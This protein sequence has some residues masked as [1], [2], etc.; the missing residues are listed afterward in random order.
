MKRLGKQQSLPSRIHEF[1]APKFT[2]LA[3]SLLS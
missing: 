2:S 3:T 1:E